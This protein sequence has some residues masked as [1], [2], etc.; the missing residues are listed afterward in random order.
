MIIYAITYSIDANPI[1]QMATLKQNQFFN[2][3][4]IDVQVRGKYPNFTDSFYKEYGVDKEK[5]TMTE[6][7]FT[8]ITEHT[9]D[10]IGFSYYMSAAVDITTD[11]V[12]GNL[13]G[14]VRNP[15]LESSDWD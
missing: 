3:Y 10:Y 15:F 13:L 5:L 8:L 14:S 2:Y 1:N 4:F 12:Q 9:V 6:E 11:E 7:D